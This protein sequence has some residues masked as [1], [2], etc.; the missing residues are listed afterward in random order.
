MRHALVIPVSGILLCAARA[1]A[2]VS[3]AMDVGTGVGQ[4]ATSAWVRESRLA[5]A[6][7]LSGRFGSLDVVSEL[8]ERAGSVALL[9]AG[10][11]G[12]VQNSAFGGGRF[13]LSLE[14][15][16]VSDSTAQL[17][18]FGPP[19][20]T[21]TA[22]LSARFAGGRS[23]AWLGGTAQGGERVGLATGL[24]HS[25]GGVVFSFSATT[26]TLQNRNLSFITRIDS[27]IDSIPTDTGFIP[28]QVWDTVI[29]TTARV[30]D[31]LWS[32]MQARAD[33][34]VS[35]FLLSAV[36]NVR[37]RLDS[38]P[39][40][41]W[42]RVGATTLLTQRVALIAGVGISQHVA[43]IPG[44]GG[45]TADASPQMHAQRFASLGVR[46]TRGRQIR[47]ALPA[48]VRPAAQSLAIT[49]E[50]DDLYRVTLRV[51]SARSVEI[52]GDF[53]SWRPVA[54]RETSPNHWEVTL[55]M[56]PGTHRINVRV[57]GDAWAAPA[58]VATV[59]D[60]FNGRVGVVVVP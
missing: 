27:R 36:V 14:G 28:H 51:P 54:L 49:R 3:S 33:W 8:S 2:Q 16:A 26:R 11:A 60:E 35:R 52:A 17:I 21:A 29:D 4:P 31:R 58:G 45:A 57:N 53:C 13:R 5:P 37:P 9:R 22:A 20:A 40:N 19:R 6:A 15:S 47:P 50:H 12:Q 38:V 23:G 1:D 24:W 10:A 59:D 44:P 56:T 39:S 32:E 30:R 18:L 42:A 46:L 34:A 55:P 41:L 43:F 48:A 7:Q 25:L